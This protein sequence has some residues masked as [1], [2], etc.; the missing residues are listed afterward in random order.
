MKRLAALLITAAVSLTGCGTGTPPVGQLKDITGMMPELEFDMTSETGAKVT[1]KDFRG[2]PVLL[3]FGYTSCPDV[4]PT[5]L[6]MVRAAL[7]DLGARGR[8]VHVL[9]VTVDPGRDTTA[10]LA[11]Y[12]GYFGPQ[13][14]GLTG[15]DGALKHLTKRYRVGYSVGTPDANGNYEVTHSSAVFVFDDKGE[16][17]YLVRWGDQPEAIARALAKLV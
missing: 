17:R 2:A 3:Y 14:V 16:A 5:T 6:A 8:N 10:K 4:C 11:T 7:A 15:D 1:A 9:F 13:F 12:L